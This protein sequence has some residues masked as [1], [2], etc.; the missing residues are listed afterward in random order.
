VKYLPERKRNITGVQ[1]CRSHL[2]KQRL[3]LVVVKTIYQGYFK[4]R[5]VIQLSCQPEPSNPP[6]TMITFISCL[7]IGKVTEFS[8]FIENINTT[9]SPSPHLPTRSP[10]ASEAYLIASGYPSR[11][12]GEPITLLPPAAERVRI[13]QTVLI[14]QPHLD[15]FLTSLSNCNA[16]AD[17]F[18]STSS[19][20]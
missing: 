13:L 11:P 15:R 20:T 18:L 1:R 9:T 17:S 4:A 14:K 12:K 8:I 3:K 19:T 10:P 5:F 6:P 7:F 2:V 16:W